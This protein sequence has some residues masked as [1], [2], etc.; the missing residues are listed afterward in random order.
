VGLG[1]GEAGPR[2]CPLCAAAAATAL[3]RYSRDPWRLVACAGC[4]LVYLANPPATDALARTFAWE[5]TFDAEKERRLR[6]APLLY[7][8]DYATRWR[9][10]LTRPDEMRLFRRLF[11]EGGDVLD[12][13]CGKG[14][15]IKPPFRPFGIEVSHELARRAD[16]A[17][18]S[19]GGFC[20][21]AP[22]IDA[23]GHFV[24]GQFAG[25]VMRSYLEHEPQPV[26]I[27]TAAAEKLALAGSIYV[28]VPNYGA[29]NRRL[30]GRNWCGFRH[31]DHVNYFTLATL[32]ATAAAAGLR[33]Q[34]LNRLNLPLDDNIHARLTRTA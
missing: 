12:V 11:G 27:L 8:L 32:K 13:G 1:A 2:R 22:A 5:K 15:R 9:L 24:D 33:L 16:A 19:R 10:R 34:L 17:M 25:I 23:L 7:R 21:C 20:V 26:E 28:K 4:G 3:P 6:E 29:L 30:T 18:R 14:E 31:P